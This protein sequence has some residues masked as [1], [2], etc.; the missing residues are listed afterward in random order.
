LLQ[1]E[2]LLQN[3]V[4]PVVF[5]VFLA[6]FFA[7]FLTG[8]F[9]VFLAALFLIFFGIFFLFMFSTFD[10]GK[11]NLPAEFK[12]RSRAISRPAVSPPH[13]GVVFHKLSLVL[14]IKTRK[15]GSG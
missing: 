8:L 9:A 12:A 10:F 5:L 2:Q 3:F 11:Q 6:V 15:F 4:L 7:D 13:F 14:L 1:Y